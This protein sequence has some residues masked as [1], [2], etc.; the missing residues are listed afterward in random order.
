M[1]TLCRR[2]SRNCCSAQPVTSCS[3][4]RTEPAVGSISRVRHRTRVDLPLPD[5]PMTTNTS[6]EA[7]SNDTSRTAMTVL[8]FAF[9]SAGASSLS[10]LPMIW[11]ARGPKTFQRPAQ[12]LIVGCVG[13]EDALRPGE[14]V[15]GRVRPPDGLVF[16]VEAFDGQ[17]GTEDL[18]A[19]DSHVG[20][21]AGEYRR[22]VEE[23]GLQIGRLGP[24]AAED[25][26]GP[27]GTADLDVLL[28]L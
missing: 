27:F 3:P 23:A 16:G 2:R 28:D 7:T 20:S 1:A 13:W 8:C 19:D 6:P 15:L 12:E 21:A 5:R 25:Q 18:L 11:R 26:P 14:P 4:M 10:G 9:N 17:D 22:R 24:A